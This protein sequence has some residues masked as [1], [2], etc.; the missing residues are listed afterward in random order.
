MNTDKIGFFQ[1]KSELLSFTRK[2][3]KV[4][5][6]RPSKRLGQNFAVDPDYLKSFVEALNTEFVTKKIMLEIG[7]GI[8]TLTAAVAQAYSDSNIITIEK[9][10]RFYEISS[11]LLS[12]PNVHIVLGDALKILPHVKI[13]TVFSSVPFSASSKIVL[14]IARNNA[15]NYAVL[16]LQKEVADRLVAKPGERSYGRLTVL[17][18]LLFNVKII[19][20][21]MPLSFYPPP[22]V[23]VTI[24]TLERRRRYEP[25]IHM[26]LEKLTECIF[27]QRN[28][29]AGRI[30]RAC[31]SKMN[32]YG[33][34]V[35]E[36][37]DMR[38]RD[39]SPQYL[40]SV[41]VQLTAGN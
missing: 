19:K 4:Y 10:K 24:V 38:V 21:Y 27:S 6:I 20:S 29:M 35:L 13:E 3:L 8:G 5:K 41:L 32:I 15:V 9:D 14:E 34:F 36:K 23:A 22:K 16:G 28:K 40:E 31:L 11:K 2:V 17:I 12:Y 7:T 26:A 18:S 1:E 25:K 33:S 30:L 37:T 39:L